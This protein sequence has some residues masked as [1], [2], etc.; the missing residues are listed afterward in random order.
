[1]IRSPRLTAVPAAVIFDMDGL[2]LDTEPLAARAWDE[3]AAALGVEFDTALARSM[4]GRNWADCCTLV[5]ARYDAPYP[6]EALLST[7]HVAYDALVEREGLTIKPGLPE[8]IDWLDAHAIARAVA[9]STRRVR[10]QAKLERTGLWARVHALV[11]GDEVERGKPEPDIFLRAAALLRIEPAQCLVLE[12][13]EPGVLAALACGMV[14]VMV[15][16]L[17]PPSPALVAA[18]VTVVPSL[19]DALAHLARLP[20]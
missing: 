19:H 16:D 7:W 8:L 10:A 15:P 5:R 9:T 20:A 14:A 4:I 13:S 17:H 11:G 3:A 1:V 18:G 12:D 6:V 2:M